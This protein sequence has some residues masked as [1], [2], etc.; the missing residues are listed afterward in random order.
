MKKSLK[1]KKIALVGLGLTFSDFILS[2]MRSEE[3]D[4]TWVINSMSGIIYH[5][6]VFMMDPPSRFLDDIKAGKQTKIMQKILKTHK[7]PIYSCEKDKRCPGVVEYPLEEVI[8]T[9]GLA[10]LNNTTA[11]AI[12]FA[13]ANEVGSLHIFGIDFSY[14]KTPHFAEAGRACCEFWLSKC[15]SNGMQIEVAHSSGLLDTDVPAEQ[16]LY[17]YHRLADPFVV[18]Q[19]ENEVTVKKVSELDI[20]KVEQEPILIDKHDSHL[21]KNKLIEPKVW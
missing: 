6:R 21:K 15:I 3:Y 10:Y 16:K 1:G 2:K 4:E 5:D 20:Q 19:N 9:T 11:Y 14:Q 12:A 18:L 13:V 7:G 17:G 8:T